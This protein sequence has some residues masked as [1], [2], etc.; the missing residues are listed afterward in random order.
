MSTSNPFGR[1][2][3]GLC[4]ISFRSGSGR[5]YDCGRAAGHPDRHAICEPPA[6]FPARAAGADDAP[7]AGQ[8]ERA[9]RALWQADGPARSYGW[10][11]CSQTAQ[12]RYRRLAAAALSAAQSGDA[13]AAGDRKGRGDG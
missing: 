6:Q 2:N 11:D 12:D 1:R 8:V 4:G 13:L 7:T 3:D 9:A 10:E 5:Y